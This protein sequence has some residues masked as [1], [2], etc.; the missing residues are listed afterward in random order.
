MA[1][2]RDPNVQL[3]CKTSVDNIYRYLVEELELDAAQICFLAEHVKLP[4][5]R[6]S[7]TM[8]RLAPDM[9]V[10]ISLLASAQIA[11]KCEFTKTLCLRGLE[12]FHE[13][14]PVV[15]SRFCYS[16]LCLSAKAKFYRSFYKTHFKGKCDIHYLFVELIQTRAWNIHDFVSQ[17]YA[18]LLSY[19]G[20]Y[21]DM[22]TFISLLVKP[23]YVSDTS[24]LGIKVMDACRAFD[25]RPKVMPHTISQLP[26]S[27]VDKF[28]FIHCT[29]VF[30]IR[31]KDWLLV[32]LYL[33][34]TKPFL[35]FDI[36][37]CSLQ[38]LVTKYPWLLANYGSS[39]EASHS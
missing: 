21:E 1:E 37:P 12:Q 8:I 17:I 35:S 3:H 16:R 36:L 10:P 34:F 38:A 30:M 27:A 23:T 20:S 32:V 18:Y 4:V 5:E 13:E 11:T 9:S 29:R 25:I 6:V 33:F 28:T 24:L 2:C 15:A 19:I 31:K 14:N 7:E 39:Q 26:G 22:E